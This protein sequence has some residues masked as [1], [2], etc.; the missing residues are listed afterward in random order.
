VACS[1]AAASGSPRPGPRAAREC[2]DGGGLGARGVQIVHQ[3]LPLR[4]RGIGSL[5]KVWWDRP[6]ARQEGSDDRHPRGRGVEEVGALIARP[7]LAPVPHVHGEV[8]RRPFSSRSHRPPARSVDEETWNSGFRLG[9]V[10]LQL[11][12]Q[13]LERHL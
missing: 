13:L 10:R 9:P 7:G 5:K 1:Q 2:G 12:N 6:R 4:R 11:L 3:P 8:E